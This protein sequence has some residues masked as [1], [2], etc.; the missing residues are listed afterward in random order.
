[1]STNPLHL[2][3][4]V[5]GFPRICQI[6]QWAHRLTASQSRPMLV[7]RKIPRIRRPGPEGKK[8]D[9]KIVCFSENGPTSSKVFVVVKIDQQVPFLRVV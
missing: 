1:M 7:H 3:S 8:Y 6:G 4:L 9:I 2:A 5:L